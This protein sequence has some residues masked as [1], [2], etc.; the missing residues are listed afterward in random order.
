MEPKSTDF[1]F[2]V[3]EGFMPVL[4]EFKQNN[5][6]QVPAAVASEGQ[7]GEKPTVS[8]SKEAVPGQ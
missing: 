8:S 3:P 2:E 4:I 1:A 5:I 6:A 7:T